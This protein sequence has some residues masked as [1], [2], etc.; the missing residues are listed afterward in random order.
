MLKKKL[1]LELTNTKRKII[2]IVDNTIDMTNA[3]LLN[4]FIDLFASTEAFMSYNIIQT[5]KSFC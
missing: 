3:D 4:I 5:N 1:L 2:P